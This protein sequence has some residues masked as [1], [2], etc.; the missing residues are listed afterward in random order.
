MIQYRGYSISNIVGKKGFYDTF[1]LLVWGRWPSTQ[2]GH[3]LQQDMQN[4]PLPHESVF[5]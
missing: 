4:F 3:K 2:E 1:H 5:C